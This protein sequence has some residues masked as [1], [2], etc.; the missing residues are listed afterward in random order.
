MGKALISLALLGLLLAGCAGPEQTEEDV[1]PPPAAAPEQGE[2][3]PEAEP[4]FSE[5]PVVILDDR[6]RKSVG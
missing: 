2:D 1:P 3:G 6:D 4:A 5:E